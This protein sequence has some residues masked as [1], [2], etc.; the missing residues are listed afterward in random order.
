MPNRRKRVPDGIEQLCLFPGDV[1]VVPRRFSGSRSRPDCSQGHT[2]TRGQQ[3]RLFGL[4][5]EDIV[6]CSTCGKMFR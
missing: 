5:P 2:W 1:A 3:L 4:P 6:Y